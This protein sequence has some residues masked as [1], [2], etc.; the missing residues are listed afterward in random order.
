MVTLI[1]ATPADETTVADVVI[2]SLGVV[3]ALVSVALLLGILLAGARV[4]WSRLHPAADDHLPPVTPG[5]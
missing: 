3:G 2:G 1:P 4:V 5:S